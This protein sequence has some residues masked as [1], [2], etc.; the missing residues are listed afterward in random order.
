MKKGFSLIE[1]LVVIAIVAILAVVVVLTLN[2][3]ELFRQGRDANRVSDMGTLNKAV[4]LYYQDARSSPNTMF[5]G[6]SSVIYVSI[7]DPTATIAGNQCQ[8]LGL[9]A[10][11][12]GYSYQCAAT[13]TYTKTD[14]T[15]WI[16]INFTTYGSSVIGSV[17][18]KLPV[19]PTNT[20]STNLYYTYETDGIGG[21]KVSSFFESQKD[22]PL[23]ASDGGNDAELYEKGTNLALASGRGLVG[24][25]PMDE[26]TGS[27][28]GVSQTADVSGNGNTGTWYGTAAGTNSTYYKAGKTGPWAGTF[29]SSA[30]YLTA[31]SVLVNS[32]SL[33]NSFTVGAWVYPSGLTGSYNRIAETDY[34]TGFYL[35]TNSAMNQFQWIVKNSSAPFNSC[36][37][38]ATTN[39][40]WQYVVGVYN[41]SVGY[42]YV[43]GS[44]VSGPIAFTSPG[45]LVHN[46]VIGKNANTNEQTI[47]GGLID[48]VR[49]YNRALS[50]AEIQEMYNAEK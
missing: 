35:G 45:N 18:S 16:P 8:G 7:P 17:I 12:T 47:W 9:P 31:P 11:P 22:A 28:S 49:V 4:S 20:T 32:L 36:I 43:N 2:P 26:G 34:R 44:L 38:G 3:G 41:G 46:M 37:G 40:V 10:A 5:M 48:D 13:S 15:G 27:T 24:Y 21:F 30:A 42:L 39:N 25:W 50:A 33:G 6:T 23:M 14:G 29:L 1:L 19:D